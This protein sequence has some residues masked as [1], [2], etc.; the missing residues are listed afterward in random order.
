MG[1]NL[2]FFYF[3]LASGAKSALE[4]KRDGIRKKIDGLV[5]CK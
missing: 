2:V 5:K 3:F 1:I 4:I